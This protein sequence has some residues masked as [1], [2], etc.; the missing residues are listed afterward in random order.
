MEINDR[1]ASL[2][3]KIDAATVLLSEFQEY[4][5][6][7]AERDQ[8][9][10]AAVESIEGEI[11]N[12][13]AHHNEIAENASTTTTEA[14]AIAVSRVKRAAFI[15]DRSAKIL[16]GSIVL[17]GLTILVLVYSD[18]R[19]LSEAIK[20]FLPVT[21]AAWIGLVGFLLYDK[22]P[23]EISNADDSRPAHDP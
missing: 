12:M 4:H 22:K 6:S 1:L 16:I 3:K 11:A 9:V 21:F 17:G 7:N 19:D 2:E 14:T 20:R 13:L 8:R 5:R 10:I 15:S 23:T 18:P